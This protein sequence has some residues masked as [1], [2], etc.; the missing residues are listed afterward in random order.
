[1]A[2]KTNIRTGRKIDVLLCQPQQK[3]NCQSNVTDVNNIVHTEK[4][5][6]SVISISY[7]R[8]YLFEQQINAQTN[9]Y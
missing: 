3:N 7:A 4:Q 6:Q 2:V 1:M 9:W 8:K 5:M